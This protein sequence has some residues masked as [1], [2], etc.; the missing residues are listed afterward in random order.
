MDQNLIAAAVVLLNRLGG[1]AVITPDEIK[2]LADKC[3]W[4]DSLAEG[5]FAL[6]L[7]TT[8]EADRRVDEQ[9]KENPPDE[10]EGNVE[11]IS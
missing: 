9:Q 1:G 7:I 8:A 3:L 11:T 2:A 6:E 5:G 10:S 4:F